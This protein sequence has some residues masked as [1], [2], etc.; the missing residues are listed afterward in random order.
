[1]SFEHKACTF[2]VYMSNIHFYN[3]MA[4]FHVF[5]KA[6]KEINSLFSYQHHIQCDCLEQ[7][8]CPQGRRSCNLLVG[9]N[10]GG[11][12]FPY[13]DSSLQRK[14]KCSFISQSKN[15]WLT[16]VLV[17]KLS[18]KSFFHMK[19]LVLTFIFVWHHCFKQN[20]SLLFI[21]VAITVMTV[22]LDFL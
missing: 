18:V 5:F 10:T 13:T 16:Y 19:R 15:A 12:R 21:N 3:V 9:A 11:C 14:E 8:W 1:M 6:H 17:F 22:S 4:W 20:L 7:S 2:L